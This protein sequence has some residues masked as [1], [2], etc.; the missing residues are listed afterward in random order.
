M[1]GIYLAGTRER[2]VLDWALA[3]VFFGTGHLIGFT[4]LAP[5]AS[6]P[7]PLVLAVIN[8]LMSLGH[9]FLLLGVQH[10]LRHP[11][12]ISLVIVIAVT[13]LVVHLL[14]QPMSESVLLRVSLL[15]VVF[16]VVSTITARLLWA[17]VSRPL[18]IYQRAVAIILVLY[19]IFLIGRMAYLFYVH[20]MD[21]DGTDSLVLVSV[22]LASLVF[23]LGL[24]VT[25][26]LMLFRRKEMHLQF[27]A[28]HDALTGLLNRYSMEDFAK[29]ELARARRGERDFSLITFDLDFYK[30]IND[31]YGHAAGDFVLKITSQRIRSTIREADIAFRVGGEEFLIMLPGG[32]AETARQVAE[33][34]REA[35][36]RK[37]VEYQG[38]EIRISA[39]FGVA[40][41]DPERDDWEALLK[42]SDRA[43][44][45]AKEGGR[46]RVEM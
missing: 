3:G 34:L 9:G 1:A 35:L 29:R 24:S 30:M 41:L 33:R 27:L 40:V 15:S 2:A 10:Y 21:G 14:W 17:K 6:I 43:L 45:R 36:A 13:V 5:G 18:R 38:A 37:P 42:R 39:S 7:I 31:T 22:F 4:T 20:G 25:L 44:Y 46:D 11:R 19:A 28:R 8:G 32:D 16:V 26:G 23:Y 12:W